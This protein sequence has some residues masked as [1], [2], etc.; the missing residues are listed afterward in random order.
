M[1][2]PRCPTTPSGQSSCRRQAPFRVCVCVDVCV[3]EHVYLRARPQLDSL[4]KRVFTMAKP[5]CLFGQALT[6]P[7]FATLVQEY[8]AAMN[9]DRPPVI[10]SAWDRVAE[11]QCRDG[12]SAGEA[13]YK[14]ALADITSV[15]SEAEA[16]ALHARC[17]QAAVEAFGKLAV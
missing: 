8:C 9:S 11:G 12:V 16:D 2:W 15:V 5:K 7:M 14:A 13:L 17:V 3:Y 4:R 1:R 10:K 6:G